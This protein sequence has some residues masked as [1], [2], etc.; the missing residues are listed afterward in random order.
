MT[1]ARMSRA[2][3]AER[4]ALRIVREF[5]DGQVVN[6]GAG[7]PMAC[8]DVIPADLD[9]V[10]HTEQGLLGYGRRVSRPEDVDPYLLNAARQALLARPGMVLVDHAE[11]FAIVRSGRID[12]TVLGALQ[13][14]VTGDLANCWLPDKVAGSL[15]GAQ[16]LADRAAT[17]IAA[18]GHSSSSGEPRIVEKLSLPATAVRCV[19]L[20]VTELAVLR[21]TP[22]GTTLEEYAPGWD[23][24]QIVAL[25]SA[26]IA[27]SPDVR[28][29]ELGAP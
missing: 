4:I 7:L 19:D 10:L 16:D 20:V 5:R 23:P 15:G 14:S 22:D 27:I 13:V 2:E 18:M 11:S 25:G 1:H 8:A 28:D 17:V 26:P 29:I 9:I 21:V 24:E 12:I 6:L 3:R